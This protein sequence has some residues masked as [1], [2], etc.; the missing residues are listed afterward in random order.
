[1]QSNYFKK[2]DNLMIKHDQLK[3]QFYGEEM[4]EV[5]FDLSINPE[6]TD[7]FINDSRYKKNLVKFRKRRDELGYGPNGNLKYKNAG[8]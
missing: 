1:M 8:Y 2:C 3:Y 6:E 7:N 4:S 5:L